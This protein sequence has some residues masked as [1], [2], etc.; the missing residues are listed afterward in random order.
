MAEHRF[1]IDMLRRLAVLARLDLRDDELE[2][3]RDDFEQ[4][5]SFVEILNDLDLDDL[6]PQT[7]PFDVVNRLRDD[8][9]REPMPIEAFLDIAPKIEDRFLA[10]PRVLD[11]GTDA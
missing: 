2:R 1:T 11:R 9:P 10:V 5:C 6:E 3:L 8:E 4:I 7:R